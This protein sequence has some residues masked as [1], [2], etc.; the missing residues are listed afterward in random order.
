MGLRQDG[1]AGAGTLDA[2]I[3]RRFDPVVPFR[4]GQLLSGSRFFIK[5][6]AVSHL[7]E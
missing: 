1:R 5:E 3:V 6:R 7:R 4:E 2:D